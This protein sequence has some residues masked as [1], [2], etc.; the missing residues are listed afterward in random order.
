MRQVQVEV[1][2]D[3]AGPHRQAYARICHLL[4]PPE[5]KP[6]RD[7]GGLKVMGKVDELFCH[8]QRD[9]GRG[10]Q[11]RRELE[12]LR[13]DEQA[14]CERVASQVAEHGEALELSASVIEVVPKRCE[15]ETET[16]V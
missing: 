14:R 9:K 12:L 13:P 10:E 11:P 1:K 8:E 5:R 6:R 3:G 4:L 15:P 16:L 7:E 2:Q